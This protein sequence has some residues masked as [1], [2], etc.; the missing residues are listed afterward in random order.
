MKTFLIVSGVVLGVIL[1]G[2]AG[3]FVFNG[4]RTPQHDFSEYTPVQEFQPAYEALVKKQAEAKAKDNPAYDIEETV[5]IM[6]GLEIAQT[7]S[8][9][10][11][12]FLEY[13]AK[14]DYSQVAGDV[15]DAK[16]K[17]LPFLQ[18]M[19]QLQKEYKEFSTVWTVIK[20]V[21]K[22]AASNVP[23]VVECAAI[24]MSTG[25]AIETVV[26]SAFDTYE[27]E[28]ELKKS[29]EKKINILKAEYI[30][31]LSEF[32]PVYHKYMK[33]W[34]RLCL[35][36]DK[37]YLNVYS[38]QMLEAY[39]TSSAILDKYPHNREALLL[40]SLA[41][42]N[43][44]SSQNENT[45]QPPLPLSLPQEGDSLTD[46]NPKN[47]NPFY[48]EADILLDNYMNLYPERSAPALV[49]KGVLNHRLGN[50]QLAITYF[51]QAAIEYPKQAAY[52]TDLLD[53][54]RNRT[55]L[56]KTQEGQYLLR[57][58]RSTMEGY[59][60]FSPNFMKAKYYAQK[61]VMDNS[62][63]EI[64]KHFFR[65][66]NQGIYDCLLSDMQF[67]EEH[68]YSSFQRLLMEH[69]FID[70]SI[71][72]TTDWKFSKK[73]NEIKLTLNNRS[74][75][76]LEN[77][78]IFLCIHYT[79]MYKDEYDVVKT[80]STKNR[81]KPHE[82]V[83]MGTIKLSYEDKKYN[84]ITRVRGIVMTDDKICWIDHAEYK[85]SEISSLHN[86]KQ[87]GETETNFINETRNDFLK[88]FSINSET[89]VKT[90]Y[91]NI[92]INNVSTQQNKPQSTIQK[93]TSP[94]T[95]LWES[96]N[97][98]LKIEL[99]RILTLLDPVFSINPI[100]DKD[101]AITPK[102]CFLAG[103]YI[104]INFDHKSD[105]NEITSLYIYSN[106]ISLKVDITFNNSIPKIKDIKII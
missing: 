102:E 16:L 28:M 101:K 5:R 12:S 48:V 32:A 25:D 98:D 70:L 94:L 13:M 78:R 33:E 61:G 52:L 4:L 44:Q 68:L 37:A 45:T 106:F 76:D 69:S 66:G 36:K 42:I 6:N 18:E 77:V 59:G 97:S 49:L 60:I 71:E 1:V 79:D 81:I 40:K 14:Q 89:L 22:S 2:V 65:R 84:D 46:L 55:Y 92:R 74:D 99:P 39:N 19:F 9:D 54:Y 38:G 85:V 47:V 96:S 10:F 82:N 103:E 62:K 90:I 20:R 15:I 29:L 95:S 35:E 7:Q 27:K 17:L 3:Y 56:N 8:D 72:P 43:I 73:E 63:E 75:L 80:T 53:A 93:I 88:D 26:S 67:C 11:Y 34:D 51:D 31:Y 30:N 50:D 57:L 105:E 83:D 91:D 104:K 23:A 24:S 21:A 87:Y 86:K 41:S 58:Y 64:F 100:Q